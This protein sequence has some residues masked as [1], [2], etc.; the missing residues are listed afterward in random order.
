MILIKW[1]YLQFPHETQAL[2]RDIDRWNGLSWKE[3]QE[4]ES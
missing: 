1:Q 2:A 3:I 4:G